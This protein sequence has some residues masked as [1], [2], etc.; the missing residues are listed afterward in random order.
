MQKVIKLIQK[1]E[2]NLMRKNFVRYLTTSFQMLFP[3]WKYLTPEIF[4]QRKAHI[5]F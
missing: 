3:I 4:F 2:K 1:K 5:P